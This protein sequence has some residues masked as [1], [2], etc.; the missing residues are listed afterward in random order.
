MCCC[1]QVRAS[2]VPSL[3][4]NACCC[5]LQVDEERGRHLYYYFVHSR[6]SPS[7]APV[8]LW[9]NGGPG[10]SSFDGKHGMGVGHT[11]RACQRSSLPAEPTLM[12][13][14]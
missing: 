7:T 11:G 2:A 5:A 13:L 1:C 10:C 9:L 4:H 14:S 3:L 6:H 8:L 12:V